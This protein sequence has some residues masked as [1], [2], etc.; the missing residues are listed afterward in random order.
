MLVGGLVAGALGFCIWNLAH[1][2]SGGDSS[3]AVSARGGCD[4]DVH[5]S[6]RG[7]SF[8][9]HTAKAT[10]ILCPPASSDL[11]RRVAVVKS[12]PNTDAMPES[13]V[14]N[15]SGLMPSHMAPSKR[16]QM[17][18][19]KNQLMDEMLNQPVIPAD[20]GAQMVAL[21]RDASQ[22]V[23]TRDFALQHIGLYAQALHRRGAYHADSSE[24]QAMRKALDEASAETKT[25]VAAA[26][27]RALA[28]L[29]AFD[30]N[31]DVRRLEVRLAACAGD[32]A[33][34]PAARVMAIQLC[35]ERKVAASRPAIASIAAAAEAPTPLRLAA[36]HALSLLD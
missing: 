21:F 36:T 34:A 29:A 33:A 16:A 14:D 8:G 10:P 27:F 25:I 13:K 23:V 20:Y 31:V 22:D 11:G 7:T 9:H 12:R 17:A 18:S 24:A 19:D 35:G 15:L 3:V 1:H 6:G 4:V 28:D 5:A 26:A 32:A 2:M 30:P